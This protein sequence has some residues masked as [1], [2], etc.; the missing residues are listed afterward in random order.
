MDCN[1]KSRLD[2]WLENMAVDKRP[3]FAPLL[4]VAF[5][6]S[7]ALSKAVLRLQQE[8]RAPFYLSLMTS[9]FCSYY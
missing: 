1:I 2:L 6:R 7:H 4:C 5:I 8:L 3:L 9:A